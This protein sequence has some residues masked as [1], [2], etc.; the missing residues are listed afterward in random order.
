MALP[1]LLDILLNNTYEDILNYVEKF[2]PD[3]F[4]DASYNKKRKLSECETRFFGDSISD[5]DRKHRKGEANNSRECMQDKKSSPIT[6][7]N[8][9]RN[10]KCGECDPSTAMKPLYS[11]SR[12]CR[13]IPVFD[14]DCHISRQI[15]FSSYS[16]ELLTSSLSTDES[17]IDVFHSSCENCS[18]LKL[19]LK[20]SYNTGKCIDASPLAV[21]W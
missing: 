15:G 16:P 21:I 7:T 12:C 14:R 19:S 11:V 3:D 9:C 20:W 1:L 13:Y 8:L 18:S 2:S 4:E 17:D 5:D 6:C 10:N